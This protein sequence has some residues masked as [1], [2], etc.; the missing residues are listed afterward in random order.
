MRSVIALL[1]T[2]CGAATPPSV[3]VEEAVR[4]AE[5]L[6]A[7]AD[8]LEPQQ[9]LERVAEAEP[10]LEAA[11]AERPCDAQVLHQLLELELVRWR[12]QRERAPD[13][14]P[15]P[16]SEKAQAWAERSRDCDPDNPASWD[17]LG[18]YWARV[19]RQERALPVYRELM[20]REPGNPTWS[21]RYAENLLALG[22][23]EEA[24]EHIELALSRHASAG[25][26]HRRYF[27]HQ[28]ATALRGLGRYEQATEAYE[29]SIAQDR[30]AVEFSACPYQ[31][32]GELYKRTGRAVEALA[33]FEEIA[34]KQPDK[35]PAQLA[36]ARQA[37]AM[38]RERLALRY[39][40]RARALDAVADLHALE[41]AVRERLA[42]GDQPEERLAAAI[43][44]YTSGD[45]DLAE[46][47]VSP[48]LAPV[49]GPEL[50]V[51]EAL[52]GIQLMD[53]DGAAAGLD[54]IER[55]HGALPEIAVARAHLAI[56]R[57]DSAEALA[58]LAQAAEREAA[59]VSAGRAG[60]APAWVEL[61]A[62]LAHLARGW[63]LANRGEHAEAIEAFDA[64]LRADPDDLFGLLGR[65]NSATASG[66][67][68]RAEGLLERVLHL[69]PGNQYATAELAL[70]AYNRGDDET[71][72]RLFEQASQ[73]D[74][75]RYT[76]PWEGLG[77]VAL[78][79]GRVAEARDHF[80]RAIDINPDI[81]F[82][83]YNG[84]ATIQLR[85]G[86]LDEAEALL[87]KSL[88]NQPGNAEALRL[89]EELDAA[90][91]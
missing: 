63:A 13:G 17:G 14:Q 46:G 74:P 26:E 22:R 10:L 1:L 55:A 83:K 36:V 40:E 7:S 9:R 77:M 58:L 3:E 80:G 18:L 72:Q 24:L 6:L 60:Q 2:G 67:L 76:C 41:G 39:L 33:M 25:P 89:L 35:L 45:L 84:L 31:G 86:R 49:E 79:Q 15:P 32:L 50:R 12:V 62:R 51:L 43:H 44:A 30:R 34:A 81:E 38:G 42:L 21:W 57:R 20:D 28:R 48:E 70:V 59:Q 85:E 64:V 19:D 4:R 88:E 8:E 11:Y 16:S 37:H 52:I 87:R 78:R 27:L 73:S 75:E 71:A 65:A 61:R 56:A 54:A 69:S 90:R 53:Y 68:D 47:L 5:A 91:E 23:F 29:A 66:D 82:A